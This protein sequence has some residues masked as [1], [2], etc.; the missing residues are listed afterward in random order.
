MRFANV[1]LSS[2]AEVKGKDQM[3]NVVSLPTRCNKCSCFPDKIHAGKLKLL[4]CELKERNRGRGKNR[5][6]QRITS[7]RW[8]C[9]RKG[10]INPQ[11]VMALQG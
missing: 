6:T 2:D 3:N 4:I 7:Q 9:Q 5:N 10:K 8:T 11:S 1:T